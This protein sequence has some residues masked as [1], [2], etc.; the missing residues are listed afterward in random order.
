MLVEIA[1]PYGR[2]DLAEIMKVYIKIVEIMCYN[3]NIISCLDFILIRSRY[4]L[5][6]I[7]CGTGRISAGV[8]G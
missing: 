3:A 4:N 5:A 6:E 1:T 8:G 7:L 2:P